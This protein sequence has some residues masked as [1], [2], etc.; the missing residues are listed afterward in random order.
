[1]LKYS[2]IILL[3]LICLGQTYAQHI[4]WND[5]KNMKV[6]N[7]NIVNHKAKVM[8]QINKHTRKFKHKFKKYNYLYH[9]NKVNQLFDE[10][11]IYYIPRY[12]LTDT[13][14]GK[15]Y[16]KLSKHCLSKILFVYNGYNL[17]GFNN[18]CI[19]NDYWNKN[20]YTVYTRHYCCFKIDVEFLHDFLYKGN[21]VFVLENI[22]DDDPNEMEYLYT[23]TQYS[24]PIRYSRTE[25]YNRA[26]KYDVKSKYKE[27][28]TNVNQ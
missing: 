11:D 19:K 12:R 27:Q 10:M 17:G 22:S 20:N 26:I 2:C 21:E 23:T 7:T 25:I 15:A 3:L 6:Y 8:R 9:H 24:I 13:A 4:S 5:F 1:M 28:H 16:I 18:K 14:E